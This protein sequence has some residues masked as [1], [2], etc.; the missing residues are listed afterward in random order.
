MWVL[1]WFYRY[2][3]APPEGAEP[4]AS[5][6]TR[7]SR[8]RDEPQQEGDEPLGWGGTESFDGTARS[9]VGGSAA[10]GR[11]SEHGKRARG[12]T[13]PQGGG[14]AHAPPLAVR[15]LLRSHAAAARRG[16]VPRGCGRSVRS[17]AER[18]RSAAT[19]SGAQ[20]GTRFDKIP[21]S[22]HSINRVFAMH[23]GSRSQRRHKQPCSLWALGTIALRLFTVSHRQQTQQLVRRGLVP[24]ELR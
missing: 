12:G 22:F 21:L 18:L 16:L 10:D 3:T 7:N 19:S 15:Y 24:R 20:S 4:N 1:V 6:G 8:F 13:P 17:V 5:A 14:D 2:R 9:T 23:T 11:T